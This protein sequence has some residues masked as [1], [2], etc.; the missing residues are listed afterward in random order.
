MYYLG[1]QSFWIIIII[2]Y[3]IVQI[4]NYVQWPWLSWMIDRNFNFS[5]PF[6]HLNVLIL[7]MHAHYTV[8]HIRIL[9]LLQYKVSCTRT[10]YLLRFIKPNNLCFLL[11]FIETY[12]WCY[13]KANYNNDYFYFHW[14]TR[15][16]MWCFQLNLCSRSF[17]FILVIS[18]GHNC[19]CTVVKNVL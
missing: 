15:K 12:N 11:I 17:V 13:F 19:K 6:G 7:S 18:L 8:S 5:I 16:I 10:S 1:P 14:F 2:Y 4:V 3:K 9:L